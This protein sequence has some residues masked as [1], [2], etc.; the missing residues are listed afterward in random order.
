[1]ARAIWN[2]RYVERQTMFSRAAIEPPTQTQ[3]GDAPIGMVEKVG[4]QILEWAV[5]HDHLILAIEG[6]RR[7]R[8]W[9]RWIFQPLA[10]TLAVAHRQ[11][12]RSIMHDEVGKRGCGNVA[13][14]ILGKLLRCPF[15]VGLLCLFDAQIVFERPARDFLQQLA[16]AARVG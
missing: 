9:R 4:S 7:R 11:Q 16:T 13:P 2:W 10:Q 1:M 15:L 3:P 8:T 14:R 5:G 12:E 6:D